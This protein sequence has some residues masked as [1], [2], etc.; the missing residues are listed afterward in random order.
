MSAHWRLA[1]R[2]AAWVAVGA[3][4]IGAVVWFLFGAAHAGAVLYGVGAGIVSFVSTALTVSLLTGGSK[5][6]GMMIGTAS[7][8]ARLGFA[9]GALGVPAYLDLWPVA[10]MLAGFVGVYLAENVVLLPGV[11]LGRA[12]AGRDVGRAVRERVERRIGA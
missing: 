9:A 8:A 5:A 7:F 1:L 4:L 3:A 10:A 2:Y 12:G 6:A 11:L